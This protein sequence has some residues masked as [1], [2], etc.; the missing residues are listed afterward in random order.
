L[1][2]RWY[3]AIRRL[4][5]DVDFMPPGATLEN[6]PLVLVPSLPIVSVSAETAFAAATGIVAFGPRS[7]SKTR[8]FWIPEELPPGRLQRLLNTRVTE[9]S[10]LRPGAL[11]KISG[12]IC[13]HAERW[14][15]QVQTR[16]ETLATYG[17]GAPALVAKDNYH[18]LAC[19]PDAGAI[20]MFMELLCEKAGLATIELPTEVRLRRRGS[21]TFAFNYGQTPWRAPFSNE[22]LLGEP[23][24]MPRN[25]TV[26]RT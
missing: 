12:A 20:A 24:V 16:A 17:D 8:H 10:S 4:G 18:Y 1:V 11:V 26:W 23:E 13:G 3:E 25:F 21:L 14:R 2:F 9:V 22:P 5:L 6:Y 19:W 7:G 15:E